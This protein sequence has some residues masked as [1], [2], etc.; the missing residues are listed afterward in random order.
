M[1][2]MQMVLQPIHPSYPALDCLR[3]AI[4]QVLLVSPEQTSDGVVLFAEHL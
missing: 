4:L 3:D 2:C 1:D